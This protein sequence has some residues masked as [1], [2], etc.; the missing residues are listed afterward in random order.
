MKTLFAGPWVGEFGWE[1]F[2]WQ[3]ILRKFVEVRKF[4]HV[5]ISGRGINKFL[6]EDFC[7]EYIPYEPN[8]YQPD[9]F[10]NRAPI[11]GYPMPEPGSTYI[12]PNHC[13]THYTPSFS[14]GKPLW[15]PKLEQSF[16][17]YGN[18][19]K[20]KYILIHARNTNKVGTQIRNWNSDNFS[21]IVDYFSE[22]KFASI[23]LESESY[24]IKGTKDL[25]G[26]DLKELTDY[27]SSANLIIGPSSGPMHLAS[28]CG[29]KHVSWGVESNV[30][31]YKYD[32][33]PYKAEVEYIVSEKWNPSIEDVKQK[34]EI[35]L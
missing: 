34:M 11:E 7:N 1:L 33:N 26:V 16:I 13:L 31:R 30:N 23:G 27:M 2:C 32:W 8:E 19:I 18:P 12:P 9:S 21:E 25:R 15:R 5:I 28:L 10:M 29:L 35:L 24:H 14:Q 17:K 4:D 3:G 6:Y 20:E 22:Y